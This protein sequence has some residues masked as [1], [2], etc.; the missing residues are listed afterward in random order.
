VEAVEGEAF[1]EL[2]FPVSQG[3]QVHDLHDGVLLLRRGDGRVQDDA[4]GG[5]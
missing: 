3:W 5:S 2:L 4:R 1:V